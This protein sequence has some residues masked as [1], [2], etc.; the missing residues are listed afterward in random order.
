MKMNEYKELMKNKSML[1]VGFTSAKH[2]EEVF[3]AYDEDGVELRLPYKEYFF[4][5]DKEQNRKQAAGVI[6]SAKNVII[7]NVDE[8]N[9]IV[10]V[11]YISA[12]AAERTAVRESLDE[13]VK[14]G[15]KILMQG[16]I[17]DIRGEGT[18]SFAVIKFKNSNLKGL[19]WCNRWSPAYIENLREETSVGAEVE[20]EIIGFNKSKV[21]PTCRYLC[22]RNAVIGNVWDGIE[23]RYQKGDIVNVKC[24]RKWG[25][26][27]SGSIAGEDEL[28][29]RMLT[30]RKKEGKPLLLL[31]PGLTYQCY[32]TS[33]SEENHTFRVSPVR[34][35]NTE[36]GVKKVVRIIT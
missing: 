20:V 18:Q 1:S 4:H 36:P 14:K 11:S 26:F 22:A 34:V 31:V 23:K 24:V 2:Q 29:V 19:L 5:D 12:L 8:E 9:K 21:E 3:C 35:C 13:R 25:S 10:T 16:V 33:V 30:P 28:P 6:R 27:F 32:V 17:K 7:K 15:E